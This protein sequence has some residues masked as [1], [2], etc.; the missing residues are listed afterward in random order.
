MNDKNVIDSINAFFERG[1]SM[2]ILVRN[3]QFVDIKQSPFFTRLLLMQEKGKKVLVKGCSEK[4]FSGNYAI[5][6]NIGVIEENFEESGEV[7]EEKD[8]IVS[9]FRE[10]TQKFISLFKGK[11]NYVVQEI[12]LKILFGI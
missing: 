2:N 3:G 6:D 4:H 5:F 7:I 9:V 8:G 11:F 1:G 12:S 10:K